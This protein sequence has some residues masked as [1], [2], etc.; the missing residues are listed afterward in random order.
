MMSRGISLGVARPIHIAGIVTP[1][2][3]GDGN[4]RAVFVAAEIR[5][6]NTGMLQRLDQ[7]WATQC[8]KMADCGWL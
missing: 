3:V 2:I 4:G 8:Q 1:T 5:Y 7:A 6:D